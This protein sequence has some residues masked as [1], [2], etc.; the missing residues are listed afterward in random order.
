[1]NFSDELQLEM[2]RI[3]EMSRRWNG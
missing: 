1:M 3:L 2:K